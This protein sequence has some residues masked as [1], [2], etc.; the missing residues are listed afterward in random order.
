MAMVLIA[1]HFSNQKVEVMNVEPSG[2]ALMHPAHRGPT[3]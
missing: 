1:F 3:V 2:R